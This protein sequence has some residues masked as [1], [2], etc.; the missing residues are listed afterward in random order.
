M[1]EY[2][3]RRDAFVLMIQLDITLQDI[4]ENFPENLDVRLGGTITIGNKPGLVAIGRLGDQSTW[5]GGKLEVDLSEIFTLSLRAGFCVEWLENEHVGGGL[6]ISVKVVGSIEVL[7]F[8]GWGAL[9]VLLTYMLTGTNDF[10]ARIRFEAGMAIVLFGFIRFGISIEL[11]AE[12]LAHVPN[13]FVFRVTFRFE[14]PW[15]LPDVSYSLEVTRGTLAPSARGVTTSP[16]TQAGSQALTGST[17]TRVQRADGREGGEP[18]ALASVASL[19]G[20]AGAW[21]GSAAPV[22]LDATIEIGFSVMLVDH[23]GIGAT[24]PDLGVQVSGDGDLELKTRYTLV[25]LTMRRRPL[26]GAAWSTVEDLSSAASTRSFRWMWAQDSRV[27]GQVAPKRLLL[28]GRTPFTVGVDNPLVDAEV[29]T[30]NPTYPCCQVRRPDVARFDF[31]PDPRGALPDG[32]VRDFRYEDRGTIAPVRVRGAACAVVLPSA[33]GA[34]SGR[35]GS[36]EANGTIATVS[37]SEDLAAAI[38]RVAISST[39]KVQVVLVALDRDGRQVDRQLVSSGPAGFQEL[40]IVPGAPFA[41]VILGAATLSREDNQ[42]APRTPGTLLLDAVECITVADRDRFERENDICSRE[43]TEGT[44]PRVTFL[45]RHEYEISLTT[46]VSIKHS[47]TDWVSS[48]VTEKVAFTTAG[49]PGLN[50]APEPGLELEPYVVS[51]APGGCGLTYREESVHVVLSEALSIFG[52]GSGSTEAL[53]RLPVTIAIESAFDANPDAHVGKTSRTAADWFLTHRGET[54][55]LVRLATLDYLDATSQDPGVRRYL[56]LAQA[57]SGTCPVQDVEQLPRVGVEP[58][59]PSGRSLW[60]P[61]AAY[62]AVMR[63]AGSP[64]VERTTFENADL[65]AFS[66]VSGTW[67]VADGV[68]DAAG[69]CTGMFG[70]ADWDLYRVDLQGTVDPGGELGV[71]VVVGGSDADTVHAAIVLAPNGSGSLVVRSGTGAALGTEPLAEVGPSSA[72]TVEVFAD[73]V[74]ARCGDAVLDVPRGNRGAGRCRLVATNAHVASLHVH[75]VDMYPRPFRTSRYEGFAEHIASCTGVE[76]YDAG[77]AAEPLATLLARI[78]G[79]VAAAMQPSAPGA[80]RERCFADAASALAVP[81]RED[82]DR[83]HVTLVS[84]GSDRWMLLESPEPMDF[85]EEITL[86]LSRQVVHEALTAADK[87]RLGPLIE[88]ALQGPTDPRDPF[89][90][91]P[92][93]RGLIVPERMS[94]LD[95]PGARKAVYQ[96]SLEGK[97]LVVVELETQN[98]LS[99]KAPRLTRADR[100]LLD[101]VTVDLNA[102]RVI[103]RWRVPVTTEWVP[104]SVNVLEDAPGSHALILPTAPLAGGTYRLALSITRRWF[105]TVDPLGPD[106]AYL[107]EAWLDMAVP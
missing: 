75:G 32:F 30:D 23:L 98:T 84:G 4:I 64:V 29:L 26:D 97:Y 43:S 17:T 67:Q 92:G 36:F 80:D 8:Q 6:L 82:S 39:D 28:N 88:A 12:W 9:E 66:A 48:T 46:E 49:P 102:A 96:A 1:F 100:A 13:Y 87:T 104:Q 89:G 51:R 61:S 10:V 99:V 68:L 107:D 65:V 76:R 70:D 45:A 44:P 16:L 24:N 35:V 83:L 38:V 63:L 56:R 18:T 52:P 95:R 78:G 47:V 79:A 69:T 14:T 105:D 50:A 19:A 3:F 81:L 94:G 37:A 21:Q 25:R 20:A 93:V 90:R 31:D 40:A 85:T 103:I 7:E 91:I 101:G 2:D 73:L 71:Q 72:L 53:L 59:D 5:I 22:A 42:A 34:T 106:N 15:F 57:S 54:D 27:G 60:E 41:T 11:L 74:R 77:A 58:F 62:V 55:P 86:G 33:T